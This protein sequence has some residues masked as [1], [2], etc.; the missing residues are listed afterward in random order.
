[1]QRVSVPVVLCVSL[2]AYGVR[3][4]GYWALTEPTWTLPLELLHGATFALGWAAA[5]QWVHEL[6]S[7]DAWRSRSV[8]TTPSPPSRPSLSQVPRELTTTAL[9][10]LN[11]A[12]SGAGSSV[13]GAVAGL[14]F[15]DSGARALWRA[16][17]T[18]AA[19]G[20]LLVGASEL[21]AWRER[22]QAKASA[23]D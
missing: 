11:A 6:V 15:A 12:Y 2:V 5:T 10:V 7:Q 19:A 13:G 4:C 21:V 1:M 14:I 16:G 8:S 3:F 9:G 20:L 22:G 23:L 17:A 18:L